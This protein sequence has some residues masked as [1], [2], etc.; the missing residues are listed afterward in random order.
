MPAAPATDRA[1]AVKAGLLLL[2][3]IALGF[4]G[5][6]LSQGEAA[7]ERPPLAV[8]LPHIA[9]VGSWYLLF[10]LQAAWSGPRRRLHRVMGKLSLPLVV[11]L[12]WTGLLVMA[13]NYRLK[14]DA[15]LAFFNV[16]NLCQFAG[17]YVAALTQVHRPARH[18]RLML[19]AS[20]AM[21]PP[22]L[23]R[24]V[25]ALG[26]PEPVTVLLIV[27]LWVPGLRHDRATLGRV[28]GATW[29][30]VGVIAACVVLGGPV[31]FSAAWAAL[32]DAWLGA[33]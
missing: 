27:G 12:L 8:L 21:M 28:H 18:M 17:L 23:V 13:A 16:L 3:L 30:G 15:P 11:A 20:C 24:I 9:T 19:Y 14:G 4:G 29:V 2:A 5:R 32:A 26:L 33:G 25:Q 7:E 22:A 31:G 6:A 10:V 1:L